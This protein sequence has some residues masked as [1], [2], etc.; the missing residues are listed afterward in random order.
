MNR[1]L[2]LDFSARQILVSSGAG[3]AL[4][5]SLTAVLNPGDEVLMPT[6]RWLKCIRSL[7]R[8]A[9]GVPVPVPTRR[10]SGYVPDLSICPPG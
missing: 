6:P 2:D 7:V 5:V 3:Q 8:M 10:E 9:D 1:R 4:W